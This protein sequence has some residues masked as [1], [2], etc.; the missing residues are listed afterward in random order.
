VQSPT[1]GHQRGASH[2][3]P[4]R[5]I[6]LRL[7]LVDDDT[8]SRR[9]LADQLQQQPGLQVVGQAAAPS[10]AVAQARSLQPDVVV[11]DPTMPDGGP[12]LVAALCRAAPAGA[13]LVLTLDSGQGDA[14]PLLRAGARG[15]LQKNCESC[16]FEELVLAIRRVHAGELVVAPAAATGVLQELRGEAART[17]RG[18]ELTDR[19]YEV[20]QLVAQG[21]TNAE[22]ARALGITEHT[23]K[24]HLVKILRKLGVDNRVQLATYAVRQGGGR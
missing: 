15:Y 9:C 21:H 12:Q 18:R 4:G 5:A 19:E 7:L 16:T 10:H 8:L 20:L 17:P 13:V 3:L 11:L 6:P 14:S 22:I 24:G 2:E 23:V 1:P